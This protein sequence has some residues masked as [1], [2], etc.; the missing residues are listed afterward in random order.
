MA[1]HKFAVSLN[2]N[3]PEE[4]AWIDSIASSGMIPAHVLKAALRAYFGT[5]RSED[6]VV[7]TA[8][9]VEAINTGFAML[10]DKLDNVRLSNAPDEIAQDGAESDAESRLLAEGMSEAALVALKTRV[11]KPGMRMETKQ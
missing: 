5:S 3:D 1:Q 6:S 8:H 2:D 4:R 7:T 11:F 10:A 9:V